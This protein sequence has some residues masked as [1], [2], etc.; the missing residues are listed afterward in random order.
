MRRRDGFRFRRATLA[1]VDA[2]H[3]QHCNRQE[4]AL[5][6][7]EALVPELRIG[8][9]LNYR[10][11]GPAMLDRLFIQPASAASKVQPKRKE[12]QREEG[13]A[14]GVRINGA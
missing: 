11:L 12:E 4:L 7:L 10:L 6:V 3:D 5:P 1:K 13:N 8:Q 2:E 9:G 14:E